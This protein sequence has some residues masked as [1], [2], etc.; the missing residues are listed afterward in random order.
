[1][2]QV[3]KI[4]LLSW[5][6]LCGVFDEGHAMSAAAPDIAWF[7]GQLIH[8][9]LVEKLKGIK[10]VICDV[11]GTLT[12]TMIYVTGE[13]EGGRSFN[14][15]DGFIVKFVMQAGITL[16]LMSGKD[17]P[18]TVQRAKKL[19]IPEELCIV[20]L[21]SKPES[22]R[23]L[24]QKYAATPAQTLIIGDDILDAEVRLDHTAGLYACPTNAP[25]YLQAFA[26]I[27][28][29]HNGGN[30]AFRLIMDLLLY[31]RDKHPAQALIT[32]AIR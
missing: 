31:I 25:F 26:D 3:F 4:V 5:I 29:P 20:G 17:N 12:D 30:G 2:N 32:Q 24:Q 11:D 15:Q 19:G 16:T 13:G 7:R 6:P 28:I 9:P 10:L 27:V 23:M 14:V 1:M 22:V 21:T 8:K 18:S